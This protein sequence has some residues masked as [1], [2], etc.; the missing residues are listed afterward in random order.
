[1]KEMVEELAPQ[2]EGFKQT[3]TTTPIVGDPEETGRRMELT[4]YVHLSVI[5]GIILNDLL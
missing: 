4:K 3:I 1:V 2:L 5:V